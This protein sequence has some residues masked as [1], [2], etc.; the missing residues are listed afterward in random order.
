MTAKLAAESN[1]PSRFDHSGPGGGKSTNATINP[2]AA[3]TMSRGSRGIT[4]SPRR[5]PHAIGPN[6]PTSPIRE[7][8]A[9]TTPATDVPTITATTNQ[10]GRRA[11]RR[12]AGHIR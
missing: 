2:T 8:A 6:R 4:P 5:Q 9:P 10:T 7:F 12:M 1:G 3:S 11:T